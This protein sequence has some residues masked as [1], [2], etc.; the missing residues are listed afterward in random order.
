MKYDMTPASIQELFVD[1][2][3]FL[4]KRGEAYGRLRLV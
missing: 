4:T 3:I 1:R 2:M